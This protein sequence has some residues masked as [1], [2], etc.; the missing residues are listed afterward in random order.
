MK[1]AK[2]NFNVLIE[3]REGTHVAHCLEMGL[4]A[5]HDDA[6]ELVSIME[7]L[8]VRQLQFAMENDNFSDIYHSAPDDVW[9]RF[10]EAVGSREE[11]PV[12][13]EQPVRVGGWPNITFNQLL[14]KVFL[15]FGILHGAT[16][17]GLLVCR[18][19]FLRHRHDR[20]DHN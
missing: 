5:V 11:P 16:L 13:L 15:G 4:V 19:R 18:A 17:R 6:D 20:S 3:E 9:Q 1:E 7:K 14:E 8:I 2:F 10:R 12:R